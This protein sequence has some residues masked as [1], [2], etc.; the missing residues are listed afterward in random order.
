MPLIGRGDLRKSITGYIEVMLQTLLFPWSDFGGGDGTQKSTDLTSDPFCTRYIRST[1]FNYPQSES[2]TDDIFT[3]ICQSQSVQVERG[4]YELN[5]TDFDSDFEYSFDVTISGMETTPIGPTC[6]LELTINGTAYNVGFTRGGSVT[7]LSYYDGSFTTW[8]TQTAGGS[9]TFKASRISDVLTL[10][11]DGDDTYSVNLGTKTGDIQ[12][13]RMTIANTGGAGNSGLTCD[14][15]N[16][17]IQTPFG[18]ETL[19]PDWSDDFTGTLDSRL[20]LIGSAIL[21]DPSDSVFIRNPPSV[22][23]GSL[24]V[25]ASEL[26]AIGSDDFY[27]EFEASNQSFIVVAAGSGRSMGLGATVTFNAGAKLYIAAYSA[28]NGGFNDGQIRGLT[29][30]GSSYENTAGIIAVSSTDTWFIKRLGTQVTIG[31]GQWEKTVTIA[32]SDTVSAIQLNAWKQSGA[33]VSSNTAS[34]DCISMKQ[35]DI[36]LT[37]TNLET[38]TFEWSDFGGGNNTQKSTSLDS[39]PFLQRWTRATDNNFASSESIINDT[40]TVTLPSQDTQI[41]NQ[42]WP[43]LLV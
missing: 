8:K 38:Q 22:A 4:F 26:T 17:T 39:L 14:I 37:G 1:D 31:N 13:L 5:V 6:V 30:N 21:D 27:F 11:I 16:A 12:I 19:T 7:G 10:S 40:L 23:S 35:D 2:I 42:Q 25:S 43:L 32:E 24:D 18:Y 41:Q 15:S 9:W 34:F 28:N 3:V 29:Y 20:S 33:S 36:A